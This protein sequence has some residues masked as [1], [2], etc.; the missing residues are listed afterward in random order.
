M[1]LIIVYLHLFL[2][3]I[4]SS[5]KNIGEHKSCDSKDANLQIRRYHD[6]TDIL[7]AKSKLPTFRT[8][9]RKLLLGH[10]LRE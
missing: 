10:I 5:V 1:D 6:I 9:N 3:H 2:F 7:A 4:F 8:V